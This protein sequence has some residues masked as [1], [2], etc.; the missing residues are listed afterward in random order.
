[1]FKLFDERNKEL[2]PENVVPYRKFTKTIHKLVKRPYKPVGSEDRMLV[3][4]NKHSAFGKCTYCITLLM[5]IKKCSQPDLKGSWLAVLA[6]HREVAYGEKLQFYDA[7]ERSLDN[8][9]YLIAGQDNLDKSKLRMINLGCFLKGHGAD[10]IEFVN[11]TMGVVTVAG[12]GLVRFAATCAPF[13]SICKPILQA[14]A[15][16]ACYTPCLKTLFATNPVCFQV[17]AI[18]STLLILWCLR[19]QT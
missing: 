5:N 18:I 8:P 15:T 9:E 14:F 17:K 1:M 16:L 13:V 6:L 19:I 2:D 4:W 3:S 7:R 10:D 11:A 12:E